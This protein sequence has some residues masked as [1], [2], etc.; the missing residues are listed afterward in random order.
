MRLEITSDARNFPSRKVAENAGFELEG[1]RR[2]SR[3]DVTGELADSCMY[4]RV[5]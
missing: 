2:K 5:F 3:R 1:I 4:A